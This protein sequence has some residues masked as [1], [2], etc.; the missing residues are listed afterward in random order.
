MATAVTRVQ[1]KFRELEQRV[2]AGPFASPRLNDLAARR[3]AMLKQRLSTD[4]KEKS[5]LQIHLAYDAPLWQG[6]AARGAVRTLEHAADVVK[7]SLESVVTVV[8]EPVPA[9]PA[10]K[11]VVIS[12]DVE[13]SP[14]VQ[15]EAHVDRLIWG[16]FGGEEVGIR[17]MMEVADRYG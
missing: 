10:K 16:K 14:N 9:K 15:S 13:A 1:A 3:F 6:V 2:A 11:R 12:I 5:P 4:L 7:L 8:N 17:R